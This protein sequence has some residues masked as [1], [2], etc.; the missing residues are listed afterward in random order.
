MSTCGSRDALFLSVLSECDPVLSVG[1][2]R[3]ERHSGSARSRG[4]GDVESGVVPGERVRRGRRLHGHLTRISCSSH[5]FQRKGFF[6]PWHSRPVVFAPLLLRMDWVSMFFW[7]FFRCVRSCKVP[8]LLQRSQKP[9][10]SRR[11]R[12]K[13]NPLKNGWC[14][15]GKFV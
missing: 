14:N 12:E 13:L 9:S 11:V 7:C 2:E 3:E 8:F 6:L 4:P 5:G 10:T 15:I 1:S